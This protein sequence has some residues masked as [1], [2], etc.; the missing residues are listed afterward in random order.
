MRSVLVVVTGPLLQVLEDRV[1]RL[2]GWSGLELYLLHIIDTQP[3]AGFSLA[4]GALP[5]RA[6]QAH[7]RLREMRKATEAAGQRLLEEAEALARSILPEGLPVLRLQREGVP[8]N[9]I[10]AAARDVG[11]DLVVLDAEP[12]Y[13]GPLSGAAPRLPGP[14]ARHPPGP[15]PRRP[16]P[17]VHFVVDH[18]PCDVLLVYG[19]P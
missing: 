15:P 18:A 5:G 12:H 2:I 4:S 13:P 8:G 10:V 3:L 17:T 7:A 6:E 19:R 9:E 16:S 11:A 1:L 14:P